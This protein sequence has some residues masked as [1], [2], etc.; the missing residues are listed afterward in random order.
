MAKK[1]S[2]LK[3]NF[4]YNVVYEVLILIIPLIT[5]PYLTRTIGPD[6]L[7]VYSFTQSYAQYFVLFIM[8]GLR[9]Y[10]NRE[11]A[12]IREDKEKL[13]RTFSE[14]YTFQFIMLL[15]VSIVYIVGLFTI[16]KEDRT[17]FLIQFLYVLSA[18]FDINWCCFGLER[19][20][21]TV[22]RNAVIKI[23][24][25][26]AIFVFV[27]C[28][29]DI[30]KYTLI[31]AEGT[32]AS[33]LIVWPFVLSEVK[34]SKPSWHG[35]VSRIKP[36]LLLF[37]P[38][39]A[40][41][42][43][44]V[45]DKLMLGVM[46]TK[47]EVAY[48]TYAER[49]IQIPMSLITA[50]GTVMLPRT[51]NMLYHGNIKES[52]ILMGKSMQF[53]M[54]IS[55]GSTFGIMA[56]AKDL[57]PWYYGANFSRCAT[58]TAFLAPVI[59]LTSWNTVIRTQFVIPMGLDTIYLITVSSGAVVNLIMNSILIP[60]LRGTGAVVGTLAAQLTVCVSQ[61]LLLRKKLNLKV[62]IID[63][64]AFSVVGMI[65]GMAV[66]LIP[67]ILGSVILNIL[68]KIATGILIYSGLATCY[69]LFIKKDRW[70]FDNALKVLLRRGKG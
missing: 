39:V 4:L 53:S 7:G 10:G 30:W 48:Y 52:Q 66:A 9:N 13:G 33:Q 28:A 14:I 70:L 68:M 36:N 8:L 49:I 54:L 64:I 43:Y 65:M 59:A 45:M 62:F 19:F 24:S 46:D 42:L 35:V 18:G 61:Y 34:L 25:A 57:I 58:F 22:T 56:I 37:V 32:L 51:S 44:T 50:L 47:A 11:I 6:R 67:D 60:C 3:K 12:A 31:I 23:L 40:I 63:T 29:A 55:L 21:L 20:R 41:S 17:I 27:K 26:V 15:V 69:L 5:S 2:S 16:I 1:A 38:V